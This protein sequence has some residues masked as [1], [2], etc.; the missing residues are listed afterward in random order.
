M[1][2]GPRRGDHSVVHYVIIASSSI[3]KKTLQCQRIETA[4]DYVQKK[5]SGLHTD[6][7]STWRCVCLPVQPSSNVEAYDEI[8]TGLSLWVWSSRQPAACLHKHSIDQLG[9]FCEPQLCE[10]TN[11]P[12]CVCVC[13]CVIHS[14]LVLLQHPHTSGDTDGQTFHSGQMQTPE[15]KSQVESESS[16]FQKYP[17]K[18]QGNKAD[19]VTLETKQSFNWKCLCSSVLLGQLF[20][21]LGKMFLWHSPWQETLSPVMVNCAC[22]SSR[23]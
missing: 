15:T 14:M 6:R 5:R 20:A 4:N 16:Q 9:F 19:T 21:S 7:R 1:V 13:V 23:V 18:A 10:C 8:T 3:W 22:L 2:L 17:G 12:V 11:V